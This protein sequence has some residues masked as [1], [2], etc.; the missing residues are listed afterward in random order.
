MFK[1][2]M[3]LMAAVVLISACSS[4]VQKEVKVDKPLSAIIKTSKGNIELKLYGENAPL[5]V[6]NFVNLARR[7]FYDGIV[8]HRVISN[9]MIQ[10]GD[11]LSLDPTKEKSWG[12]GGPGYTFEDELN[13]GLK[14]AQ[15][16]TLSM[17]NSGANTNGS[18]IFIT[19]VPTP[20]LDGKHTIFG[21]VTQGQQVV[22]DIRQGDKII[23]VVIEGT[24]P[25]V[26]KEK[27]AR[28]DEWNKTLDNDLSKRIPQLKLKPAVKL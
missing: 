19:H 18:Q 12:T 10:T 23:S 16:G 9:F 17:A 5:T 14:H 13:T 24:V 28:I 27:Q 15:A 4:K 1:K 6:A 2:V 8:F 3:L 7:G 21:Q 25:K 22:N 26:V 20:W 11:P